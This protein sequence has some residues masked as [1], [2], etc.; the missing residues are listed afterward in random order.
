MRI[1]VDVMGG[2]HGCGVIIA[3]VKAALEENK[4]ITSIYLVG[5]KADIHAALPPRGF[6]DHRVRIV[7]ASEVVEM[8]DKPAIA[9]RKKK[10]SSIARAAELVREGKADALI[11][12]GNTGGIFA[13]GTFKVGRIDGVDRGCIATVIPRPTNEFVLLDSGANVECKPLHLAQFAVM[14]S[15]YS[16]EVLKRKNPRVGILSIGSEDSKGNE[17]TLE[18]FKLCK[19]LDLNFIGNVEG[20]DLFKDHVDVVVC[21]GFVGNIVLKTCE[22]LAVGMFTMLKR[23]LMHTAQRQLGAYLAKGAFHAIRRRM[24]PEVYGGAPLLGFNGL[25]F[26][27]HASARERAVTSAIRVTAN[28]VKTQINQTIA[29]D[30]AAANKILDAETGPAQP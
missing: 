27:A 21:D 29:R 24:D 14:G 9:L 19:K 12:L 5:N 1:A 7:H 17:L 25:V 23:E 3:G 2:D 28:A 13:A 8:E 16:R 10:D 30:I 18:A 20:H 26:K 15:V 11:S 4:D 22:S 6:R